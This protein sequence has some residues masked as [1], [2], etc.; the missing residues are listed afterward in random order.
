MLYNTTTATMTG[1]TMKP[2][3][4]TNW[5]RAAKIS[6]ELYTEAESIDF[7]LDLF[8]SFQCINGMFPLLKLML[9]CI[10]I[11]VVCF[12]A[13]GAR[14]QIPVYCIPVSGCEAVK[15]KQKFWGTITGPKRIT[16]I[17]TAY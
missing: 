9:T 10:V 12:L 3:T 2:T 7:I 17:F 8:S 5:G 4:P 13:S 14:W 6:A 1:I 11:I 16:G 15:S